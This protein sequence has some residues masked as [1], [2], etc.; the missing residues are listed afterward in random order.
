MKRRECKETT[1]INGVDDAPTSKLDGA[2]VTGDASN[3][4]IG[5]GRDPDDTN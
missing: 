3:R 1:Q 5:F 4:S 2:V